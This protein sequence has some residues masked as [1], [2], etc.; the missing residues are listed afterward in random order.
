M[1]Y[2]TCLFSFLQDTFAWVASLDYHHHLFPHK[3]R[4][5]EEDHDVDSILTLD[6]F[7]FIPFFFKTNQPHLGPMIKPKNHLP[8][9]PPHQK[10]NNQ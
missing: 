3:S 7:V 1:I 2:V 6:A 4:D 10:K 8:S 9:P 5:G